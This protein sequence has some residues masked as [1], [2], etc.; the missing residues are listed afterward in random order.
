MIK[1]GHSSLEK[2]RSTL[3]HARPDWL[4]WI[5]FRLCLIRHMIRL[6]SRV[7]GGDCIPF[8]VSACLPHLF[9]AGNTRPGSDDRTIRSINN[10]HLSSLMPASGPPVFRV[11]HCP[12]FRSLLCVGIY[13]DASIALDCRVADGIPSSPPHNCTCFIITETRRPADLLESS[14]YTWRGRIARAASRSRRRSHGC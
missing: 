11:H 13:D 2:G 14:L 8:R 9:N 10:V 12:P 4:V 6:L 3:S 7:R 1:R 5:S